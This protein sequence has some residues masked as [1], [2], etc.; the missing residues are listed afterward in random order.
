LTTTQSHNLVKLLHSPFLAFVRLT[1]IA[2][3]T[4]GGLAAQGVA[5]SSR[6]IDWYAVPGR[7]YR[8]SCRLAGISVKT[9]GDPMDTSTAAASP[10]LFVANHISYL[11]IFVLGSLLRASFVAKSEVAAWPIFGFLSKVQRTVFV[12]RRARYAANQRDALSARL[13][14]GDCLILFPEGT[15][16]CGAQ[17][18]PFK[19]ALFSVAAHEGD[20]QPVIVQPV[21]LAYTRVEFMPMGRLMRPF[22]AWYGDMELAPHLWRVLGLGKITVTVTFHPPVTLQAFG[23]RKALAAYCQSVVA[24]GAAQARSGRSVDVQSPDLHIDDVKIEQ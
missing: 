11:D 12:D 5:L 2:V 17:T 22:F 13:A 15:S 24:E 18:R 21:S 23:S 16:G 20:H 8:V 7:W 1:G 19:S 3:W 6:L 9:S 14:A 4:L 10:V